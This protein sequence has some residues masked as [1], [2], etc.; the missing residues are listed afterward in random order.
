MVCGTAKP[1]KYK[2]KGTS[3]YKSDLKNNVFLLTADRNSGK[4]KVIWLTKYDP[5]KSDVTVSETR[6][7][8]LTDNRFAILYSTNK[9]N[10]NTLHYVVVDNQGK[11]IAEKTYKNIWFAANSDP[12][13]YKGYI[14]WVSHTDYWGWYLGGK[15]V[16]YKVPVTW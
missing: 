16:Y 11:K 10:K 14:R 1:H 7:V 8:K 9:N 6:M 13:L 5:K 3:G 4:S 12:V 2:I 15:S